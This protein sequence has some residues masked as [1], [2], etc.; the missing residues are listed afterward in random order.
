[1]ISLHSINSIA[2]VANVYDGNGAGGAKE[3]QAGLIK[4]S[5]AKKNGSIEI[6]FNTGILVSKVVINC[7]AFSKN[8][9]NGTNTSMYLAV[10][11]LDKVAAPYNADATPEDIEFVIENGSNTVK[12]N[13]TGRVVMYSISFYSSKAKKD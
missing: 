1:M 8:E 2:S 10:N 5:T 12:I 9:N 7:H 4:F 6:K 11:D 3:N 13:A